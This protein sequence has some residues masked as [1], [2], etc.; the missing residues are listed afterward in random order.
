M[1]AEAAE[2]GE[3][4]EGEQTAR[5]R[6]EDERVGPLETQLR[7][8]RAAVERLEA[9]RERRVSVRLRGWWE[10]RADRLRRARA[11]ASELALRP[12]VGGARTWA[13]DKAQRVRV[14]AN[15][16]ELRDSAAGIRSRLVA[17]RPRV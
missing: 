16:T 17:R 13:R 14:R 15:F 12:S 8:A 11:A 5:A 3:A 10:R 1:G 4:L 9:E 7:E 6:L 2:L